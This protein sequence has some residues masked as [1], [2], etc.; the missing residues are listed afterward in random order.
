[1][2]LVCEPRL[3]DERLNDLG[4]RRVGEEILSESGFPLAL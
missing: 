1:L 3:C 2:R 4:E